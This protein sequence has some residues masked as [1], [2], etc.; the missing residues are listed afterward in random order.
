VQ[1]E[2]A[3]ARAAGELDFAGSQYPQFVQASTAAGKTRA[4]VQAELAQARSSGQIDFAGSQYPL[5][6]NTGN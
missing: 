6:A 5:E 1:A 2:L 3:K 4:E